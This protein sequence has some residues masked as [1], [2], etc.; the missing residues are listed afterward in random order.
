VFK[1]NYKMLK[2]FNEEEGD[3]DG[4]GEVDVEVWFNEMSD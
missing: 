3:V 1:D 4:D 2:K